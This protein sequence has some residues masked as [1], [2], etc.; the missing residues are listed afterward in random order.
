MFRRTALILAMVAVVTL[1]SSVAFAD[2]REGV[3]VSVAAG[4]L[5]MVDGEAEHPYDVGLRAKITL[6]GRK[7]SLIE[8]KAGD[9]VR[10]AQN[11]EGTVV[12]VEAIRLK[13]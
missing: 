7:A 13:R 1:T 3:I 12:L 11:L 4:K 2:V 10:V 6:D 5:V 8:L 9:G